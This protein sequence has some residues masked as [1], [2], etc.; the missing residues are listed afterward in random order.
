MWEPFKW[1]IICK[2]CGLRHYFVDEEAFLAQ[3]L[4]VPI[5]EDEELMIETCPFCA[6]ETALEKMKENQNAESL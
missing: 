4:G 1:R 2:T 3:N 5:I 6:E